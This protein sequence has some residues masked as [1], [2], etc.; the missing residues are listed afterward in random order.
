MLNNIFNYI[1]IP[2]TLLLGGSQNISW[3]LGKWRHSY[4]SNEV[5]RSYK[6]YF[7]SSLPSLFCLCVCLYRSVYGEAAMSI[8]ILC[9]FILWPKLMCGILIFSESPPQL[10]LSCSA[11]PQVKGRNDFFLFLL[12]L[13]LLLIR[14]PTPFVATLPALLETCC[15]LVVWDAV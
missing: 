9:M 2:F 5:H 12:S 8:H 14:H 15:V 7:C 3:E 10:S 13:C 6:I 4:S 1:Y 11:L